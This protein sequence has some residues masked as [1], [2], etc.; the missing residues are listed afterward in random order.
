[1][2]DL[3]P[4]LRLQFNERV[5][6]A[7]KRPGVYQVG[8]PLYH[9]DG[10]AVDLYVEQSKT[11]GLW[12]VFDAGMTLMRLSYAVE[13]MTPAREKVLAKMLLEAGV[14]EDNGDLMLEV[15]DASL[16]PALL[17][18][19][20]AEARIGAI[21]H[22]RREIV[23]GLFQEELD[24][25]VSSLLCQYRPQKSAFPL[26][27]RDDLE[28][29]WQLDVAGHPF[30]IFGVRDPGKARLATIACQAFQLRKLPF[31]SAVVHEDMMALPKKDQS[32][33]TSAADKQ[34]PTLADFRENAAQYF[35][36]EAA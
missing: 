10:D 23:A 35:E 9:E 15:P 25:L 7:E 26:D 24:E 33:L 22:F 14:Q 34:F 12:R 3:L 13:D 36:R 11:G 20:Q 19:A 31:R 32:R 17:Q 18:L 4:R 29:D 8:L 1:M 28:V 16:V 2:L 30:Y 5:A 6:V 21:R 27:D